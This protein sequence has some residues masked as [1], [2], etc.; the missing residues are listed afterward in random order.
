VN[1]LHEHKMIDQEARRGLSRGM[2]MG[3]HEWHDGS[4]YLASSASPVKP[5]LQGAIAS[6]RLCFG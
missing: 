2:F 4:T 6:M 3:I 1:T 5:L